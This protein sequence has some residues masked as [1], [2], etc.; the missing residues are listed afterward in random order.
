ME[1]AKQE[2]TDLAVN[3]QSAMVNY[4]DANALNKLYKNAAVFARSDLVPDTYKDRPENVMIAMDV[5][6]RGGFPLM[7]V[8]QNLYVVKG[9]PAWSGQF[10][11]AAINGCGRFSPLTFVAVEDGG[12]GM[13]CKAVRLED[14]ETCI[15]TTITMQMAKDEGWLNKPGSKWKSMPEQM[16]R[17]RAAAFFARTFCPDVL[18][19]LQTADE[20]KDV[21]G[22]EKKKK[23][24]KNTLDDVIDGE[25][26]EE[27]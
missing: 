7:A 12:G 24:V 2:T 9:R 23:T 20:I 11:I 4:M 22:E 3:E 1:E 17:Y 26:T 10:C 14:G 18:M 16:L 13:Y 25:Y 5:A 6:A 15:G 27:L 19:G 8:M 21:W